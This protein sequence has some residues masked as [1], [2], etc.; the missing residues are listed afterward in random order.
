MMGKKSTTTFVSRVVIVNGNR[1]INV[2]AKG[3]G[4]SESQATRDGTM[5]VLHVCIVR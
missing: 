3:N 4:R 2:V 5:R 1:R